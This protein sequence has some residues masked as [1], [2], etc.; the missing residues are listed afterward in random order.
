MAL[1]GSGRGLTGFWLIFAIT[2]VNASMFVMLPLQMTYTSITNKC[3][4]S[5]N[6]MV[7]I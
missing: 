3:L 5:F 4:N 7:R 6:V 1:G 2:L